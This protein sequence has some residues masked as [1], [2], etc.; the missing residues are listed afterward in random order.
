MEDWSLEQV[1]RGGSVFLRHLVRCIPLWKLSQVSCTKC[2][3]G[4]MAVRL[5]PFYRRS[6]ELQHHL[7]ADSEC[8]LSGLGEDPDVQH[9][10]RGS[11]HPGEAMDQQELTTSCCRG[12]SG[13][14]V[15][16]HLG[17]FENPSSQ[18]ATQLP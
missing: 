12:K 5:S 1:V 3:A 2:P 4:G 13:Q 6:P 14:L 16:N 7:G 9:D 11:C 15:W 17:H 8:R 18:A 10:P